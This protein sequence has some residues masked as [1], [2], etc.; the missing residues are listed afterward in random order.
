MTY[1]IF[2]VF[3]IVF[4]ALLLSSCHESNNAISENNGVKLYKSRQFEKALPLLQKAAKAGD[5]V[6]PFYLGIM[7]DEGSGVNK[8]QK[9]S[10]E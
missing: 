10:F 2:Q 1:K 7:F 4:F 9:K 5:P 3:Y 8:D 6:A